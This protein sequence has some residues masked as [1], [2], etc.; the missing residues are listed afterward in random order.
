MP[1]SI[2]K[3]CL[4]VKPLVK[5]H[6]IPVGLY[7]KNPGGDRLQY[8][9]SGEGRRPKKKVPHGVY[10]GY[11]V[12]ETCE[13]R[14]APWDDYA[15]E[16][17]V[18]EKIEFQSLTE[19]GTPYRLYPAFDYAKLKLFFI[20]MLWR[21]HATG[22]PDFAKVDLGSKYE[23]MAKAMIKASD[24]GTPDQFAVFLMRFTGEHRLLGTSPTPRPHM[25]VL[26]YETLL[27][28]FGSFVKAS[29]RPLPTAYRN[30]QLTDG[31][32]LYMLEKPIEDSP[33]VRYAIDAV[34]GDITA[35]ER[36]RAARQRPK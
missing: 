3:F 36:L 9:L 16:F 31:Q 20:S 25:G 19:N 34:K 22:L 4:Q 6:I 14:F 21:A 24:P 11:L 26:I 32:P 17:F 8:S 33:F 15:S 12:C 28:G 35:K 29:K 5:A 1:T 13:E 10:D 2:C 23:D 7:P 27:F 18:E 30:V